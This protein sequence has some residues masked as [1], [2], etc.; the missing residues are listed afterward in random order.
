MKPLTHTMSPTSSPRSSTS[1]SNTSPPS[2]SASSPTFMT[3]ARRFLGFAI[4]LLVLAWA[5][6]APA[7]PRLS[8]VARTGRITMRAEAGLE[9]RGAELASIAERE[10][11][12][13]SADLL[14]LPT[15]RAV[16]IQLVREAADLASVAPG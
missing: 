14:E 13:I 10:L 16:E 11:A 6:P 5:T 8:L 1:S 3:R 15:P 12:R 2:S 4:A 9:A 7:A